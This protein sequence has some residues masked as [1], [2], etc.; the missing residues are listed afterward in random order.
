MN[1]FMCFLN[2][3]YY[4]KVNFYA[5]VIAKLVNNP[6]PWVQV[7][8]GDRTREYIRKLIR[9]TVRSSLQLNTTIA[10]K[11]IRSWNYTS[12]SPT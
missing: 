6:T 3:L 11:R 9:W 5:G 4:H 2:F 7:T 12:S 10:M 8:K 1:I